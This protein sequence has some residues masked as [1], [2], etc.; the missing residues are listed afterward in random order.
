MVTVLSLTFGDI[1]VT[2]VSDGHLVLDHARSFPDIPDEAY[3]AYGGLEGGRVVVPMLSFVVHARGRTLLVDTGRGPH[4]G[5]WEGVSGLL[6][7][8]LAAGGVAPERVDAV[9]L[10]HLHADHI[11]WNFTEEDG[12]DRL[13]FPNARE[14]VHRVEWAHWTA[15]TSKVI[16]RQVTPL[17]DHGRLKL[18]DDGHEPA[19]GVR[20]LATPGHTPG[21]VSVL[22]YDGGAGGVITGD[23]AHH[24]AELE[25][26]EWGYALDQDREQADRARPALA[27]RITAE[28]L[29]A[30]GGHFPPP[31]AGRLVRV[32]SGHVYRPLGA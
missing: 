24:P 11:G 21:H 23:A 13:T 7:G 20:L 18:V 16:A 32:G 4:T 1:A 19:P 8:A 12:R 29:V 31:H 17:A 2:A 22:V 27:E 5:S 10:T 26:P 6:P 9:V 28:G 15:T 14:L 3:A 25:R 30:L